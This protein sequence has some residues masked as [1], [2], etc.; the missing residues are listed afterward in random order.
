MI[1]GVKIIDLKS[2]EDER[3]FFREIFR[4]KEQFENVPVGQLSHS[5]VNKNVV[6]RW[7]SGRLFFPTWCSSRLQMC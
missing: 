3:G 4:F 6:R 2:Y 1:E 5:F 7:Y